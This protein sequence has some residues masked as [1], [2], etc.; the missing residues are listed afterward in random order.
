MFT[1]MVETNGLLIISVAV[2]SFYWYFD[3]LHPGQLISRVL[4]VVLFIVYG[5]FTQYLINTHKTMSTEL[6][7]LHQ[8]LLQRVAAASGQVQR[9]PAVP[10]N[11]KNA[12]NL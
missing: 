4:T 10:A 6:K 2:A 1:R 8:E 5:S 12:G 11:D 9:G 3:S 7:K